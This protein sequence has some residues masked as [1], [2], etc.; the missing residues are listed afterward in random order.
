MSLSGKSLTN[1]QVQ[2]C[3]SLNNWTFVTFWFCLWLL[4]YFSDHI[5]VS[6][7]VGLFKFS[8]SVSQLCHMY[9]LKIFLT[10]V[11]GVTVESFRKSVIIKVEYLL[12]WIC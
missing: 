12:Y 11:Y 2:V 4:L 10:N 1:I 5:L 9:E 8:Y 6:F 3:L 7:F